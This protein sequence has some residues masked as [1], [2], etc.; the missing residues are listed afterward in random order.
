MIWRRDWYRQGEW[1]RFTVSWRTPPFL[2]DEEVSGHCIST[3]HARPKGINLGSVGL[4]GVVRRI[5]KQHWRQ[6]EIHTHATVL[7][8]TP[9]DF[10]LFLNDQTECINS[11]R[12]NIRPNWKK[13]T[14]SPD[15]LATISIPW[16]IEFKL[17]CF[18][19]KQNGAMEVSDDSL[20]HRF[21]NSY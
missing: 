21:W 20:R 7:I 4:Q 2:F 18:D 12:K 14:I 16:W 5:V 10:L 1:G 15:T 19:F 3:V 8:W 11:I 9:D 6:S 13:V 17:V